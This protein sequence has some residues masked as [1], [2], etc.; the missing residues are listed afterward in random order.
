MVSLE[1]A[2]RKNKQLEKRYQR[3]LA[4]GNRNHK[5]PTKEEVF[6]AG[7]PVENSV[8]QV[9]SFKVNGEPASHTLDLHNGL[10]RNP[11]TDDVR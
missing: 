3:K 10:V 7:G 8:V 2:K 5:E 4:I 1:T 9:S 11:P 6:R